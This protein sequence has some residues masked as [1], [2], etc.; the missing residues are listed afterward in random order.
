M[1]MDEWIDKQQENVLDTTYFHTVFTIP[2]ELNPIVYSNQEL[3]YDALYMAAN[4]TLRELAANPKYLGARIGYIC[5]LHTW[6]SKM[7]YHP[8]IHYDK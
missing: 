5:V 2:N 3:L 4:R 8:H 7:N 6:G 1:G